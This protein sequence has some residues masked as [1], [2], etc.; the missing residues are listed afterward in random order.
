MWTIE[1]THSGVTYTQGLYRGQ[2][3]KEIAE[4]NARLAKY[5]TARVIPV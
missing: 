3:G 1:Y 2:M 5:C 4:L